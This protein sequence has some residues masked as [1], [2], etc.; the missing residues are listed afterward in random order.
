M[1]STARPFLTVLTRTTGDRATLVD[2][3]TCL[4]GQHDQ[5]FE[6]RLMVS[7]DDAD[8][9]PRVRS[10]VDRFERSFRD[11]VHV[12]LVSPAHRVRPL[13][14]GLDA[15]LGRYLAVLDDDDLVFGD[16]VGQFH[17]ASE[18]AGS[19]VIRCRAVDQSAD[20]VGG[21]PAGTI[22]VATSGFSTPYK[23]RFDLAR[24]LVGGQTP[25]G[26][27][28]FPVD[29]IRELGLRFDEQLAVCEDLDFLLRAVTVLGVVDTEQF[30]MVYRRWNAV[31]SSHHT[32]SPAVWESTMQG[33][34]RGLDE[35]AI[36]M[37]PGSASRLYQAGVDELHVYQLS[38]G[39]TALLR[40]AESMERRYLAL[41][42]Q[43]D[44][45]ED[46]YR[47]L[48]AL[49]TAGSLR[50]RVRGVLGRTTVGQRLLGAFRRRQ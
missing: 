34:V 8:V 23:P 42:H 10:T 40:R 41:A 14:A 4:A 25:Q 12:H 18:R 49:V 45:L 26:S 48:E 47:S 35:Q 38:D 29:P 27:V 37:P 44:D 15:A 11:R 36:V 22:A 46:R 32:I 20:G 24:H 9:E 21:G 3:L 13:N 43:Y 5:D 1:A 17:A 30:G 39:E 31:H 50:T 28:A 16:W 19:A 7:A 33:I 2:T 6:V